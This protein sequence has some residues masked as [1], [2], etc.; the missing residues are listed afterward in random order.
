MARMVSVQIRL[1][2]EEVNRIDSYVEEGKFSSR[3]DFIRDAVRKAEMLRS[4]MEMNYTLRKAG[5]T[6]ED[7]LE[8][9]SEIRRSLFGEMFG[10]VD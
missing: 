5:I 4:M 3:S 1:P 7:L 8:G 2:S 6:F 9:G 10:G